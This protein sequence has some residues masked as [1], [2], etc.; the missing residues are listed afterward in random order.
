ML[1]GTGI[2]NTFV[3]KKER[4]LVILKQMASFFTKKFYKKVDFEFWI[5]QSFSAKSVPD[6]CDSPYS[7]KPH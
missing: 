2:I 7:A 3:S 5:G 6:L 4:K 1:K